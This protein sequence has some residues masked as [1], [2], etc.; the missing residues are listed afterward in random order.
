MIS[1]M[2]SFGLLYSHSTS[3]F[4][5]EEFETLMDRHLELLDDQHVKVRVLAGENM[6]C[7]Q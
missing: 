4:E 5:K 6:V 1:A 7:D 3:R 2:H